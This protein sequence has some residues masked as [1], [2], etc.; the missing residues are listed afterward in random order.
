VIIYQKGN[1]ALKNIILL[2]T[3]NENVGD[4]LIR[5][6]VKCLLKKL[7]TSDLHFVPW[8]KS[9][10]LSASFRPRDWT[11]CTIHRQKRPVRAILRQL[12]RLSLSKLNP[13]RYGQVIRSNMIVIC[14]TPLFYLLDQTN[15]T[16][17]ETW[18]KILLDVKRLKPEL[19][20]IT[21]GC[22]S[23]IDC[24]IMEV[25]N[26][27][28]QA[29]ELI[30]NIVES[31]KFFYCRDSQTLAVIRATGLGL[32]EGHALMPCP[33]I[34]AAEFLQ[35]QRTF[36]SQTGSRMCI[37]FSTESSNWSKNKDEDLQVR[38]DLVKNI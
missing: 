8:A 27:F 29:L 9:N 14:G 11:V 22:G 30:R 4:D 5:L 37:G 31:Q 2:S 7:T 20:V 13:L 34:W 3:F 18:W 25:V 28:P 1:V 6:G 21:L 35:V 19:P 12:E 33:S 26:R 16:K 10:A 17:H 24:S 23:I 15:F 38:I 36:P 32:E